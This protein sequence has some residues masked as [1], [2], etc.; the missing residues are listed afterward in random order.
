MFCTGLSIAVIV[1]NKLIGYIPGSE[2][3]Y[4]LVVFIKLGG[5]QLHLRAEDFE[6][7]INVPER[8]L[9]LGFS[10]YSYFEAEIRHGWS[11]PFVHNLGLKFG[12][13]CC[14]IK[15]NHKKAVVHEKRI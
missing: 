9:K 14:I 15:S 13:F 2:R 3:P 1:Y 11:P 5:H 12:W 10:Y 8:G 7:L 6:C 4:G